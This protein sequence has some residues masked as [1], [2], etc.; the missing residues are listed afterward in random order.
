MRVNGFIGSIDIVIKIVQSD[1]CS[2]GMSTKVKTRIPIVFYPETL[3]VTVYV[4]SYDP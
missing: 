2:I 3:I 4:T 1:I